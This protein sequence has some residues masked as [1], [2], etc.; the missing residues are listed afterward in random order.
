MQVTIDPAELEPV[1]T[2]TILATLLAIKAD[3]DRLGDRL[4]FSEPEAARLLS[5]QPHQ[6]RDERLRGRLGASGIPT[7]T[8]KRNS[9]HTNLVTH[10]RS[11]DSH[12]REC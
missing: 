8:K 1:I 7:S 3:E 2:A 11:F 6:L 5:M 10:G 9:R 4:A 12:D